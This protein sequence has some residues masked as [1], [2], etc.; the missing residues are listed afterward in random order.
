MT[1]FRQDIR[2]EEVKIVFNTYG[3]VQEAKSSGKK[4]YFLLLANKRSAS[5][6][7]SFGL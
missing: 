5:Y 6:L 4:A 2:E 1:S 3:T 7:M